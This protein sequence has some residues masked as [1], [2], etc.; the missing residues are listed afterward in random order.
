MR[1]KNTIWISSTINFEEYTKV[2]N[3]EIPLLI[4]IDFYLI[5]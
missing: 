5:K 1:Q 4:Q 3:L 2:S